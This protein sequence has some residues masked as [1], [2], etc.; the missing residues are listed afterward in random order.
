MN[1]LSLS[2]VQ[3]LN[4]VALTILRDAIVRDPIAACMT[5]GLR[6]EELDA[7]EPLLAPERILAAVANAGKESLIALREDA[8]ALLSRPAPLVGALA[9]VRQRTATRGTNSPDRPAPRAG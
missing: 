4:L 7:L 3:Y 9:A 2:E 8:A 6:R 5:F 1:S